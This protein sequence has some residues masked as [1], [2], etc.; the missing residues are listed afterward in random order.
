MTSITVNVPNTDVRFFKTMASKMG[1]TLDE[2]SSK[3]TPA[4]AKEKTLR[5]IDRALGQLKKIKAGK[6]QP[7]NAEDL[8][9]EL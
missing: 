8:A 3:K 1:W 4:T 7:V 9:N 2:A 5:K 6:I